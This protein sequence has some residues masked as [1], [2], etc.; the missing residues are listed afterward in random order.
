MSR[1][2]VRST[3]VAALLTVTILAARAE[4][5]V[6]A[7]ENVTVT[8]TKSR[9]VVEKFVKAFAAP[10]KLSG[11]IARWESGICPVTVGQPA[12]VT[13]LVTQHVKEIAAA[14]GAPISSLKS[15]TPNIQIVFTT[16][17]QALLN[18]VRKDDPDYL[19][20]ATSNEQRDALAAVTR[21]IQAW[22]L[23]ET[24]DLD[25][26]KKI[27]SGK[28]LGTGITM[29]NFSAFSLP[30]SIG[31]NRDPIYLPDATYA[32]VTGNRINDGVRTGF[33]HILIA[34]D[35]GKLGGKRFGPLADYI[36]ML[37]LT[38]LNALDT[39][40]QLPSIV[41]ILAPNC[42][43]NVDG[44]TQ[45]DLAYLHGL[46][47]MGSDK[48]LV[49]QQNDIADTMTVALSKGGTVIAPSYAPAAAADIPTTRCDAPDTPSAVDGTAITLDQLNASIRAARQFM[50]A[51]DAY[52]DCLGKEIDAQKAA[53]TPAKPFNQAIAERD[54][55]LA[56]ENQKIKENVG[57]SVNAA[58]ATYKMAHP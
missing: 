16:T 38:Q 43:Q 27:D 11:K 37:A 3:A 47:A 39:C 52:Q 30:S 4:P 28:R 42:D 19:G 29:S 58:I 25:G 21:P 44:I 56:A 46:Y 41:N 10:T 22:Y 36:A 40:Q 45:T 57:A 8:A 15:C 50:A 32:R 14:V 23:T 18:N 13:A 20:Y 5:P 34:V 49:F 2:F 54:L 7:Q 17:P 31:I 24:I 55:A 53:A 6:P 9:E 35:S 51:S 33:N 12:Q 48:S 26:M 1:S